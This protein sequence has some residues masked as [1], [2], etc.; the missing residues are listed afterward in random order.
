MSIG[1]F[2]DWTLSLKA[3]GLLLIA[4]L[5]TDVAIAAMLLRGSIQPASAAPLVSRP[6]EAIVVRAPDDA[7]VAREGA[8]RSPFDVVPPAPALAFA[9]APVASPQPVVQSPQIALLGTVIDNHGGFVMVQMPD[10][11]VQLVHAGERAGEFRLRA[12]SA[13]QAIFEDQTGARTT[14]RLLTPGT[15]IRP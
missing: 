14:L 5:L 13:G 4:S 6:L 11:R 9:A 2:R 8:M 10:G 3:I 15:A 7:E 1:P 12:V